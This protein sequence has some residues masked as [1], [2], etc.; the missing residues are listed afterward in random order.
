[1]LQSLM[2]FEPFKFYAICSA[3]LALNVIVL[4]AMTGAK[5]ARTKSF[6]NPEDAKGGPLNEGEH[7]DVA[8]VLRAHRNALEN[9]P[10]FFAIGLIYTLSGAS[11]LGAKVYFITFT[12]A[13]LLHSVAHL[14]ALQPWRSVSFG[15]GS[16]CLL[17]MI[18]Q[19][20]IAAFG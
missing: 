8:R 19:I 7:P 14:K 12:A 15:I 2:S 3:I 4:G 10:V 20:G 9:I 5:R 17:G 16:L 13:R 18:V 6:S 11:P 1:M